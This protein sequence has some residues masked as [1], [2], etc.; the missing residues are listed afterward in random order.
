MSIFFSFFYFSLDFH[1]FTWYNYIIKR[2]GGEA[3][4]DRVKKLTEIVKELNKLVEQLIK[5]AWKISTLVGLILFICYSV[6]H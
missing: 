6:A 4:G 5:L 3:L 1:V 2:K